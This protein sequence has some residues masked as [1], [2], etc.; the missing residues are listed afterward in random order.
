MKFGE[1]ATFV[2]IWIEKSQPAEEKEEEEE[3][4]VK[5]GGAGGGRKR[6]KWTMK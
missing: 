1:N 2:H 5:G 4:S 6:T 3:E